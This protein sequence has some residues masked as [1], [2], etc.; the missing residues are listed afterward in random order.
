MLF[1]RKA[2]VLRSV[3]VRIVTLMEQEKYSNLKKML[4]V[5]LFNLMSKT[6]QSVGRAPRGSLC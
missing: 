5:S 4:P 2:T 3:P 6:L 1:K